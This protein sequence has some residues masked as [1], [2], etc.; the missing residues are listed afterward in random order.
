MVHITCDGG[1]EQDD[2]GSTEFH[3]NFIPPLRAEAVCTECGYTTEIGG[4][5][6]AQ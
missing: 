4:D 5:N 2:C 3:I 1:D 6:R